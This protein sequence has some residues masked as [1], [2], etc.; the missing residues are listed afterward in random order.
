MAIY[1]VIYGN[2][3]CWWYIYITK[4]KPMMDGFISWLTIHNLT[5]ICPLNSG[6]W[7]FATK[8]Q[9]IYIYWLVVWNMNFIFHN[10]WDNP[11]H[12][13]SYFSRWLK[14]PTS[15]WLMFKA[16]KT[17]LT[18]WFMQDISIALYSWTGAVH[19]SCRRLFLAVYRHVKIDSPSTKNP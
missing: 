5:I 13:L 19:Q 2:I 8:Y 10:I 11:S 12:W 6:Y 16:S 7:N 17:G 9:F 15:N 1:I 18:V 14:P 4:N 3:Y